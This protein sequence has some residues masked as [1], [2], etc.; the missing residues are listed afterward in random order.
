MKSNSKNSKKEL[1]INEK[2][3][4]N[5]KNSL[6]ALKKEIKSCECGLKDIA[7]NFVFSD[8][9]DSNVMVI[10]EAP[11]AEEDKIGKPFVGQAG[12]L[13]DKMLSFIE[14]DRKLIL[15]N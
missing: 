10:G 15:Y 3:V 1:N 7:T 2:L 13:L 14:L 11:G 6:E 4:K 12:K 9:Q 8:E 5:K